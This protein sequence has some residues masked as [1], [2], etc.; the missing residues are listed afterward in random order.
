VEAFVETVSGQ[1][2]IAANLPFYASNLP[3]YQRLLG[4]AL[5]SSLQRSMPDNS[6]EVKTLLADAQEWLLPSGN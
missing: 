3:Y 6:L 1:D 4:T 5:A 2:E